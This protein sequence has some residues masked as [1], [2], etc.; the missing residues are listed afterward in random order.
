MTNPSYEHKFWPN[1]KG[2]CQRIVS[3]GHCGEREDFPAHV[4]WKERHP[5]PEVC[6]VCGLEITP[7]LEALLAHLRHLRHEREEE[8]TETL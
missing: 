3:G 8:N 4:R 7:E 5:P 2:T 6:E 1:H